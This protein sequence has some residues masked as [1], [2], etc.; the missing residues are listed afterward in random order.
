MGLPART[1]LLLLLC[2]YVVALLCRASDTGS[3]AG[4][5][6]EMQAMAAHGSYGHL[7]VSPA[8]L[9]FYNI[10]T[11]LYRVLHPTEVRKGTPLPVDS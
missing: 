2:C 1:C 9:L 10:I 6:S 7:P 11:V 4:S 8:Q 3:P 5:Y